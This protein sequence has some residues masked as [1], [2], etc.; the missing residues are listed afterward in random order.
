MIMGREKY[1]DVT[2]AFM[3]GAVIG[4]AMALLYAPA[5]G[6]AT[7]RR[8]AEAAARLRASSEEKYGHARDYVVGKVDQG[9]TYVQDRREEVD[10][11]VHA[12]KEAY[13]KSAEQH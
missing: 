8:F 11:A 7:R 10:A 6:A 5:S 2:L 12:G 13:Q 4:S 1:G 3:L 9:R